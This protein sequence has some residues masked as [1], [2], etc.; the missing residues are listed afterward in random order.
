MVAS[1]PPSQRQ[2]CYNRPPNERGLIL[3]GGRGT[4]LR[5]ITFTSAK[6]LVPVANKPILFYG[7]EALAASGILEIGIVVG[8]HAPGDPRRGRR[9]RPLRRLGH[10]HRARGPARAGPRASSSPSRFLGA[11]PFCMYLGRQPHPRAAGP[12]GRRASARRSPTAR[13]SSPRCRPEPVRR[14]GAGGGPGR[15]A[16]REARDPPVEPGAGRRVHVRR[17]DLRGGQGHP[18]VGARR[19]RDHR[20]HPVADRPWPSSAP[21]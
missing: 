9:R 11:D 2:D 12:A 21:T 19:A 6:Q 1:P 18:A 15:A 10:L 7:I 8:R 17:G 4:R 20:R 14:G 13:S 5:P 16:R 3:S